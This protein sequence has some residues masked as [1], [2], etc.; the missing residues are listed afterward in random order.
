[1]IV[2]VGDRVRLGH[3]IEALEGRLHE[4]VSL[5]PEGID[6]RRQENDILLAAKGA[7]WI[8]YDTRQYLNDG[9]ELIEI[10][11]RVY[12]ANKAKVILLVP[13]NNP[14]NEIVKTAIAQQIKCFVN[15]SLSLAEQK[16]ELE[17]ILTGYYDGNIREDI[18]AAEEIVREETKTLNEFVG[19]LYDAKQREEEKEN[20]IIVKKKGTVQVLLD[21]LVNFLK[22]CATIISIL[23]MALA[24][25]TLLYSN[26]RTELLAN[27]QRIYSDIMAMF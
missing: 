20:T 18:Q 21:F 14:N 1:M 17:K 19:E 3:I 10:I 16:E 25:I 4:G 6:I 23:L 2:C 22:T 11:K 8:I 9:I 26:T 24:I 27:L 13:T 7:S 12:R 5:V 15:T